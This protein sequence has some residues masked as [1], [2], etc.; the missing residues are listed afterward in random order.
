MRSRPRISV[1]VS[2]SQMMFALRSAEPHAHGISHSPKSEALE[3]TSWRQHDEKILRLA[4]VASNPSCESS[5]AFFEFNGYDPLAGS[6][7]ALGSVG[8]LGPCSLISPCVL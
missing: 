2:C 4:A 3:G 7:Y 1:A 5:Q 8:I 6:L